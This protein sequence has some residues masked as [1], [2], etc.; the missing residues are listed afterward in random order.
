MSFG[1]SPPAS[2]PSPAL[3]LQPGA[4]RLPHFLR[5]LPFLRPPNPGLKRARKAGDPGPRCPPEA[6]AGTSHAPGLVP[7]VGI[8]LLL[9]ENAPRTY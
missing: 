3:Q 6:A 2:R 4:A 7:R 9:L 8:E 1:L 5:A